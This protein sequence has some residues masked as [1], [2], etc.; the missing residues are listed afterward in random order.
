M[1]ERH[2]EW[3]A[4]VIFRFNDRVRFESSTLS[5]YVAEDISPD[6]RVRWV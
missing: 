6:L 5:D 3:Y 1:R 4:I 2:L